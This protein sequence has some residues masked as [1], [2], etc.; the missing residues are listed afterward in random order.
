MPVDAKQFREQYIADA[1]WVC[2]NG[3][4]LICIFSHYTD[5]E[6]EAA[7]KKCL[8]QHELSHIGDHEP[9]PQGD[10]FGGQAPYKSGM[11]NAMSELKAFKESVK[12]YREAMSACTTENCFLQLLGEYVNATLGVQD[13]TWQILNPPQR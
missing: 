7:N 6:V 12:C 11:T 8:I 1:S 9:C 4:P 3:T 2:C 13:A 5:P 10:G